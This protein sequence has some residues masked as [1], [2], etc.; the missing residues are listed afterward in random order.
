[1]K[2]I[3]L[4]TDTDPEFLLVNFFWVKK[5]INVEYNNTFEIQIE[6]NDGTTTT[7]TYDSEEV[8]NNMLDKIKNELTTQIF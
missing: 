3:K 6:Y 2:F 5:I 7:Y 4:T 8:R 1:M